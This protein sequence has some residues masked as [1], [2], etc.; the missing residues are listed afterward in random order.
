MKK[1]GTMGIEDVQFLDRDGRVYL[2]GTVE[3]FA[4][5]EGKILEEAVRKINQAREENR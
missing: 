1:D 4:T 3:Y 2:L 5:D